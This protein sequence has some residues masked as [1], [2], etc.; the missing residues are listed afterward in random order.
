MSAPMVA[1]VVLFL[2]L[3]MRW[4]RLVWTV[5]AVVVVGVGALGSIFLGIVLFAALLQRG[6]GK[7][8]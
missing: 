7:E 8:K 1:L 6:G 2:L 3:A 4:P 5:L